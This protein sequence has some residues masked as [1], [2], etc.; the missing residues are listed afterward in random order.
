LDDQIVALDVYDLRKYKENK[1]IECKKI[2]NKYGIGSFV[3]YR[4]EYDYPER[5]ILIEY[6]EDYFI[7]ELDVNKKRKKINYQNITILYI[8]NSIST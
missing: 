7:Y 1:N 5:E 2:L 4:D 6:G 3:A 8:L